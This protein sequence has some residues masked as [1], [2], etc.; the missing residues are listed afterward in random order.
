MLIAAPVFMKRTLSQSN[1]RAKLEY[2][3]QE[4]A[5]NIK[6]ICDRKVCETDHENVVHQDANIVAGHFVSS[7]KNFSTSA[8]LVNARHVARGY[9]GNQEEVLAHDA[10]ALP[11]ISKKRTLSISSIMKWRVFFYDLTQAYLHSK[12]NLS[13]LVITRPK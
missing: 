13:R 2:F 5:T 8:E 11:P 10:A 9:I 4:K 3:I 7:M 12:D 6:G 1:R